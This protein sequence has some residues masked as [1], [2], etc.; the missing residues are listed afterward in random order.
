[1]N[2]Q[3]REYLKGRFRD[4]YRTA[5]IHQPP[6]V[7]RRELG[8]IPWTEGD[9]TVMVRHKS[10]MNIGSIGTHL[11]ENAPQHMYYSAAYYQ[12]PG[13]K[14]GM[15]NKNLQQADLIFDIDADH[16]DGV[17]AQTGKKEA[18]AEA[19]EHLKQLITYVEEDFGFTDYQIV[20]SGNRG[21]HLHVRD[22]G[23]MDLGRKA[24]QEIVDYVQANGLNID[25]LVEKRYSNG[26]TTR[27]VRNKGGWG[28]R[29]YSA[30]LDHMEGVVEL[31]K[32]EAVEALSAYDNVGEKRA[33]T[34]YKNFT[35]PNELIKSG[36]IE[37][38]GVGARKIFKQFAEQKVPDLAVEID[39][40][41][42]TDLHRLI[43]LPETIHGGSG[44]LT[45]TVDKGDLN[46][47]SPLSD[48]IP[49]RFVGRNIEINVQEPA[50]IFLNDE[51]KT[52]EK[53]NQSVEEYIGIYL[54]ANGMAEKQS[55]LL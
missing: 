30:F 27:C 20:F 54:M 44:L 7:H 2:H 6:E 29:L 16:L 50:E 14:G 5:D 1:M 8:Y 33:R 43:R 42:T 13:R 22:S 39:A 23:V 9:E 24:R 31:E 41:V 19:K 17:T 53:G 46:S 36:V 21:Y 28:K 52:I 3:T 11:K 26:T 32:K 48:A 55:G 35:D 40:P 15:Q 38:A 49:E 45:T 4:Y 25:G 37:A 12:D 34:A 51:Q 18:L 10:Q 47:F